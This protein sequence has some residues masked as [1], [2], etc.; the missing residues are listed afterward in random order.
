MTV[1]TQQSLRGGV[2]A[3]M[4]KSPLQSTSTPLP[5]DQKSL[6]TTK[7]IDIEKK[8]KRY[9]SSLR[10]SSEKETLPILSQIRTLLES[11][12]DELPTRC[13]IAE[14]CGLV[15]VLSDIVSSP[16]SVGLTSIASNLLALVQNALGS[17]EMQIKE[18]RHPNSRQKMFTM[19]DP[20]N[21]LNEQIDELRTTISNMAKQ[22]AEQ[23]GIINSRLMKFESIPRSIDEK[24]S[25][26]LLQQS[27]F[28]QLSKM[29]ADAIEIYDED[30]IIKTGST[31]KLRWRPWDMPTNFIP[32][33][34]FSPII[35]SDVAQLLFTSTALSNSFYF[36]AVPAHFI[37]TGTCDDFCKEKTGTACWGGR[38]YKHGHTEDLLLEADCRIGRRICKHMTGGEV[39]HRVFV[40]LSLPFRFAIT[41]RRPSVS[42]TIKSLTFTA[43]PILKGEKEVYSYLK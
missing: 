10:N 35:S 9:C 11:D 30:F 3:Q 1:P 19:G 24:C 5:D 36:G 43:K 16:S 28:Q 22:M 29:G 4:S 8:M 12:L 42:V 41:L 14:S 32:K 18:H 40:N 23:F 27:R 7:S 26:N 33:T 20:T 31:F 6:S 37:D 17:R 2:L 34:L 21:D 38:D 15:S 25:F 39:Q 13:A